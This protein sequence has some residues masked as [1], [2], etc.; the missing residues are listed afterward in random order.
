MPTASPID[1]ATVD[2]ATVDLG[3][4]A[5]FREGPP[6]ALFQ[7]LR[8]EEPVHW[9]PANRWPDTPG[10]WSITR[11]EDI[12]RISLD[13]ETFSSEAGGIDMSNDEIMLAFQRGAIIG[14]DPPRHDRLKGLF[15]RAFTPKRVADH[16]PLI[17]ALT[18]RALDEV[19]GRETIDLVEDVTPR[20]IARVIGGLVGYGPELDEQMVEMARFAFQASA[21]DADISD[22]VQD[23]VAWMT[24]NAVAL[25]DD[26]REN[27]TDDLVSALLQAEID[28]ERLNT[29]EIIGIIAILIAAGND[30]TR[31][32]FTGGMYELLRNPDQHRALVDDP[33]RIPMAVEEFLRM[34]PPFG[35]MA[36]TAMKDVELHGK[37]IRPGDKVILWYPSGNM[38]ASVHACP[39]QLD[40]ERDPEH[41]SFGAG[42]RH[43]CLGA[44]LA[45]LQ[46]RVLFE[47]TLTRF[48]EMTLAGEVEWLAAPMTP[49]LAHL[50]VHP[51]P[52][53]RA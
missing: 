43:F 10:F 19:E 8:D 40:I 25:V 27:P 9:S 12:R 32:S 48:P 2:L 50:P 35:H 20:T 13:W 6:H 1:L 53:R 47:E 52:A 5:F 24:R 31:A 26:R 14:M 41:Q 42:G 18:R 29:A 17:R 23:W 38:D 33:G 3:D 30:S 49:T 44:A 37:T 45:R 16:E 46:L 15:Q 34:H 11:P 21:T 39:H 36:R 22:V 51:G 4:P 7:R 28:G